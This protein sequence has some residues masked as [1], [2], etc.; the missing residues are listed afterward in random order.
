MKNKKHI[1]R[2]TLRFL[3]GKKGY[4]Y[5]RFIITHHYFPSFKKPKTFSEKIIYRKFNTEPS[6]LSLYVDKYTVRQYVEDT[7]GKEYLIPLIKK[8]N[9][10]K[11]EDFDSLPNSFVIKTSNGG[12]E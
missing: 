2:D 10:I 6:S 3:L 7:I 1:L 8:C 4:A 9:Y 5:L 11:P 12:G